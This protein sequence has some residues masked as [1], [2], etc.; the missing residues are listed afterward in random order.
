ML[1]LSQE[2]LSDL[3]AKGETVVITYRRAF[4][5]RYSHGVSGYILQQF[6][7]KRG[8]NSLAKRGR[9]H[10]FTPEYAQSIL[11]MEQ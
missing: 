7:Y 2:E 4:E 11:S 1:K 8:G 9:Y 5:I 3:Y 6:F 10:A